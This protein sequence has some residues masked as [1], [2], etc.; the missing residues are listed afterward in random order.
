MAESVKSKL[1]PTEHGYLAC[2]FDEIEHAGIYVTQR[3]DMFR[4]P[5]DALAEGRSPLLVWECAEGN[6]VTRITDNAYA[7]ISK[8]RQ[9]AAD[10]DLPVNF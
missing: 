10:F 8:C 9:L 1:R 4:I 3:G 2:R 6:L 7:P 5:N